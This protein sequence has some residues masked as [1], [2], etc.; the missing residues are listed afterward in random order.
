MIE[1]SGTRFNK[2]DYFETVID[3]EIPSCEVTGFI[4]GQ[5]VDFSGGG[6]LNFGQATSKLNVAKTVIEF[7]DIPAEPKCFVLT[8]SFTVDS[9]DSAMYIADFI[10]FGDKSIVKRYGHSSGAYSETTNPI[11]VSFNNNKLTFTSEVLKFSHL[12]NYKLIYAY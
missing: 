3:T 4:D 10:K 1:R 2:G 9:A 5:P 6:E 8:T 11:T 12:Q 7:N